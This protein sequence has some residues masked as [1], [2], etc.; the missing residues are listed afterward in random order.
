MSEQKIPHH[1]EIEQSFLAPA[2]VL[3]RLPVNTETK[4]ALEHLEIARDYTF[5]ARERVRPEGAD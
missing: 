2:K 5:R 1:E 3:A 4:R